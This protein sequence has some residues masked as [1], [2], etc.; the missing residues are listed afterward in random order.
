MIHK[1]GSVKRRPA[2]LGQAAEAASH[3][4]IALIPQIFRTDE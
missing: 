1:G 3:P 2:G 4:Q